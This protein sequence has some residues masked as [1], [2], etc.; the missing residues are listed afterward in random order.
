MN[1]MALSSPHLRSS[2]RI[3]P[4]P[5]GGSVFAIAPDKEFQIDR[6]LMSEDGYTLFPTVASWTRLHA[7]L[8]TGAPLMLPLEHECFELAWEVS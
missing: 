2:S 7:G 3:H 6:A 4:A 5:F 8:A 1:P